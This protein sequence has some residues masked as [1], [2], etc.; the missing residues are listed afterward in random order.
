M[1]Q[2]FSSTSN[3]HYRQPHGLDLLKGQISFSH[4]TNYTVHLSLPI[5]LNVLPKSLLKITFYLPLKKKI[6]KKKNKKIKKLRI[7]PLALRIQLHNGWHVLR[8]FKAM[9]DHKVPMATVYQLREVYWQQS[10]TKLLAGCPPNYL[11]LCMQY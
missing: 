7:P 1:G 2:I 6:N 4:I 11:P 8:K 9:A 5:N 10:F 3:P